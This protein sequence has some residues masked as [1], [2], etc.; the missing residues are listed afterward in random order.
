[1]K[2]DTINVIGLGYIGLPT[3]LMLAS[4][5]VPVVTFDVGGLS[6]WLIPGE[7]GLFAKAPNG[8]TRV[9]EART[10]ATLAAA[11]DQVADPQKLKYMSGHALDTV[12]RLFDPN[13]FLVELLDCW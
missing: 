8:Q 1:M 7:T 10:P 13:R 3:A 4:H 5:G 6:D 2:N 9:P 11:L 12:A